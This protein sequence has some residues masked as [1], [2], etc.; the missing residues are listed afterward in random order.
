MIKFFA[1]KPRISANKKKNGHSNIKTPFKRQA[2]LPQ[3][4]NNAFS[5]MNNLILVSTLFVKLV[6][7]IALLHT[8]THTPLHTHPYTHTLTHTPLH[9]HTR[10]HLPIYTHTLPHTSIRTRQKISINHNYCLWQNCRTEQNRRID[11]KRTDL[12]RENISCSYN[13]NYFYPLDRLK[14]PLRSPHL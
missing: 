4:Q 7:P 3:R 9:T 2:W 12:S 14:R 8:H 5:P 10:K 11:S 6:Y 1:T 13:F